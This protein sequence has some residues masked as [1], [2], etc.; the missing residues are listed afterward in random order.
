MV[1]HFIFFN[2][3]VRSEAERFHRAHFGEGLLDFAQAAIHPS[4]LSGHV[5]P[6]ILD[7]GY[8]L[9]LVLLGLCGKINPINPASSFL[10][11]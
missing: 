9:Q 7:A 2:N 1:T 10:F 4:G 8:Q 6:Q 3:T 5:S 11:L